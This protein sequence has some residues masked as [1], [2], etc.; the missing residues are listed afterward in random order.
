MHPLPLLAIFLC[1]LGL[2]SVVKG[3]EESNLALLSLAQ[4]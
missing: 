2:V 4:V 1:L 3:N